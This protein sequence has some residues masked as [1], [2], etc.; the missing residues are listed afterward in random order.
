MSNEEGLVVE[1]VERKCKEL[2]QKISLKPVNLKMKKKQ[3]ELKEIVY[4][5]FPVKVKTYSG[6]NIITAFI[7]VH[8]DTA[9]GTNLIPKLNGNK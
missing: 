9:A 3:H 8:R 7:G 5:Y 6:K 4:P 1:G 2:S